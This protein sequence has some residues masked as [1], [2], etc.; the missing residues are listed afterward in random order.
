MLIS[1]TNKFIF[2]HNYKVAGSSIKRALRPYS[3]KIG[4][5]QF[6]LREPF[7]RFNAHVQS[8]DIKERIPRFIYENYFKFGFVRDPWDWQVS[9]YTFMLKNQK[10]HQHRLIKSMNFERYIDWRVHQELRLQKDFFY[11]QQGE[12][13]VDFVGKYESL[14]KDFNQ[15]CATVGIKTCLPHIN[16]SK[17]AGSYLEYHTRETIDMIE[18]AFQQD[19]LLFNYQKPGL[20]LD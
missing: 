13:L 15:V 3:A 9:L 19:I 20:V 12:C 4:F 14:Q 11:N 7:F 2:V 10:H 5:W 16:Q 18:Q 6:S 17:P 8:K 1:H